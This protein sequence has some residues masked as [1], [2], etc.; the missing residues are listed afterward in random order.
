MGGC[1]IAVT[2]GLTELTEPCVTQFARRRLQSGLPFLCFG[3][4]VFQQMERIPEFCSEQRHKFRVF[5][6]FFSPQTIIHMGNSC[7]ESGLMHQTRQ[8]YRI[9]TSADTKQ[10]SL[11]FF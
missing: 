4:H 2:M 6:A 8:A 7:L 3:N 10:N 9:S 1:H 5:L 11:V